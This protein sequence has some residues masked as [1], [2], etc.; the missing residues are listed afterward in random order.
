[1]SGAICG[2]SFPR[3]QTD[4]AC[5]WRSCGLRTPRRRIRDLH[6]SY[7]HPALAEHLR[8]R[9]ERADAYR[10]A[11]PG[12][13]DAKGPSTLHPWAEVARQ[14]Q[15]AADEARA[16]AAAEPAEFEREGW[17]LRHDSV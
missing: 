16:R 7:M 6:M 3:G 17:A 4:P 11:A 13:P 9:W 5:R 2:A 10:F 15:M 12:G 8:K 1:M 14:E